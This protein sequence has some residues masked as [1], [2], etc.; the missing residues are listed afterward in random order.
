MNILLCILFVPTQ[1]ANFSIRMS[2]EMSDRQCVRGISQ[3][4][5]VQA[6]SADAIQFC[7]LLMK[8]AVTFFLWRLLCINV[9]MRSCSCFR[10]S[11]NLLCLVTITFYS[12]RCFV[13]LLQWYKTTVCHAV[14]VMGHMSPFICLPPFPLMSYSVLCLSSQQL[15]TFCDML[16][17]MD[18]PH[19]GAVCPTLQ[20]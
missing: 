11:A 20:T 5:S 15:Y 17:L 18:M 6:E 9:L 4:S 12:W 16:S 1:D 7:K 8:Q 10:H 13:P 2:I 14:V 3:L 19:S